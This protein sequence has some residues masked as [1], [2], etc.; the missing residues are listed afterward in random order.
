MISGLRSSWRG[1]APAV[2]ALGLLCLAG[3]GPTV[4]VVERGVV[5]G[6]K[7]ALNEMLGYC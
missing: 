5:S 3:C 1:T 7:R 2:S 6:E 4:H